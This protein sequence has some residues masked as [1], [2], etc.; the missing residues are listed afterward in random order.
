M[1]GCFELVD[2]GRCPETLEILK[3]KESKK[4]GK[5]VGGKKFEE[6]KGLAMNMK[7]GEKVGSEGGSQRRWVRSGKLLDNCETSF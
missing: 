3:R 6:E 7:A 2:L 5:R 4:K 1:C